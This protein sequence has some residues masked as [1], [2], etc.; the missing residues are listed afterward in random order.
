MTF[1]KN[2]KPALDT[3]S[4][5]YK[6]IC[7]KVIK[8]NNKCYRMYFSTDQKNKK[9][10]DYT[11]IK[12]AIS[13]DCKKWFF[14]RGVRVGLLKEK[15]FIRALSPSI[16]EIEKGLYRMY[17]EARTLD[18]KSVIKSA[19][20]NDGLKWK[21]ETGNRLGTLGLTSY[22]TPFC[23]FK[24]NSYYQ[25]FFERRFKEKRD[26]WVVESIDGIN[27]NEKQITQV[28]KQDKKL[29]SYALYSPDV[30]YSKNSYH[31]YYSG[32]GGNPVKGYIFYAK[33]HD[34][35]NWKKNKKP[36]ISPGGRYDKL[37]C[38]EP[39]LVKVGKTLK[40]FYE[41]CDNNKIWRILC[42]KKK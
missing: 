8:I 21:E 41:G 20:S 11:F 12:S 16:V 2:N 42:A 30:I 22:G 31:M 38:S 10:N 37:Y 33:S 34:G 32:W 13:N 14:E 29:E 9:K 1:V 27:F 39:S 18:Q 23:I 5:N 24:K 6:L 19:L 15:K 35:I 40:I 36:I 28:I 7:P 26:I 3:N 17:F 4:S 25:L